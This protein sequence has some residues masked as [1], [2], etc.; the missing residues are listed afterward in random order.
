MFDY[1]SG[2]I[3]A[4]GE[5][6]VVIDCGGVGFAVTASAFTCS[7][8]SRK[9]EVK[10][11]VYLAV[12]E[13]ALELFGFGSEREREL[14]M[15]LIGVSGVGPKL[16]V[17]VLGGMDEK[18]LAAAIAASDVPALSSIKGVGKKTAERIALELK[19]KIADVMGDVV[20]GVAASEAHAV[21]DENAVLALVS[22]GYDRKE[23]EAAVKNVAKP[24]M[25]TE[26]LI[27]EVLRG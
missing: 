12:R 22:L 3:A 26:Q 1:I 25:T 8:C 19:G 23:A 21:P 16:A 15:L 14:F 17:S 13:D 11:P 20:I 4:V 5:N 27:R 10:M 9:T 6:R 2:K 18:R 24:D 7:E